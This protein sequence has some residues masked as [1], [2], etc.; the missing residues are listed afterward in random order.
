MYDPNKDKLLMS[1]SLGDVDD[2]ILVRQEQEIIQKAEQLRN[3]LA[4]LQKNKHG[5]IIQQFKKQL[6]K[7]AEEEAQKFNAQILNEFKRRV[8]EVAQDKDTKL[9]SLSR[10]RSEIQHKIKELT[11]LDQEIETNQDELESAFTAA[12]EDLK[13]EAELQKSDYLHKLKKRISNKVE[14]FSKYIETGEPV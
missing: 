4:Q 5:V 8:T 13:H 11:K 7:E 3:E 1:Q 12:V 2:D 6:T 9:Y 14:Q 10:A